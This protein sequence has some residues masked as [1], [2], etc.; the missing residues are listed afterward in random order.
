MLGVKSAVPRQVSLL[1][2]INVGGRTMVSMG[3]LRDVYAG[4]GAEDVVTVL[5]SGNVVLRYAGTPTQVSRLA[6]AAIASAFGLRVA[7]IGRTQADLQRI[8]RVTAFED[9]IPSQRFVVFLSGEPERGSERELAGVTAPREM[10]LLVGSELHMHLPDG[11]GRSRLQL[12][13]IEKKLGVT[14]TARNWNTV[15]K[16]AA[17]SADE[18]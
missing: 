2:G 9:A 18:S 3:R 15:M 10:V 7:V 16:L 17:L 6:E 1:R 13:V 12:P 5:Q 4:F 14:G 11:A 8:L